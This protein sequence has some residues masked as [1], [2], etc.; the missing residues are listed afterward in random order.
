[1]H[2]D[3][4]QSL[5]NNNNFKEAYNRIHENNSAIAAEFEKE[6]N[7]I[8]AK[9]RKKGME[10]IELERY[11]TINNSGF[12]HFMDRYRAFEKELEKPQFAPVFKDLEK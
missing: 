12:Y 9:L 3:I 2:P 1:M 4:Y 6:K 8:F 7:R 10:I 5:I 11:T